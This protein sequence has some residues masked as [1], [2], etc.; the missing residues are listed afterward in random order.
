MYVDCGASE[1]PG[2]LRSGEMALL[3]DDTG[4]EV[5]LKNRL[6]GTTTL[7]VTTSVHTSTWDF[8]AIAWEL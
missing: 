5:P 6:Q 3:I 1:G 7:D 4:D 8:K 2:T